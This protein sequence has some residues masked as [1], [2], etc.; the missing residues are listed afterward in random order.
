MT[1]LLLVGA[2]RMGAALLKGWL[3]A[4]DESFSFVVLDPN[5]AKLQADLAGESRCTF[6]ASARDLPGGAAVDGVVLATK[7]Q[8]LCD[9]LLQI[10]P[11]IGPQTIVISIAAGVETARIALAAQPATAIVRAMPNIGAMVGC[12]VT[13]AYAAAPTSLPQ[14]ALVEHLFAAIGI[15]SWVD[16]EADLHAVTALSGSGPAYYFALCEAMTAAAID[17]GLNTM[18]ARKLAAGTLAA[19][20]LLIAKTPDPA[21]LRQMVTSPNGTTAAGLAA[22]GADDG[23]MRLSAQ[24]LAAAAKRSCELAWVSDG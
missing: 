24:A 21:A 17:L 19:A 9:A 20:G 6:C 1:K 2:G 22:L 8:M 23:L 11:Q 18:A 13:A 14:Q 4:L 16:A 5:V 7:P 15:F 10:A 3:H 12:S